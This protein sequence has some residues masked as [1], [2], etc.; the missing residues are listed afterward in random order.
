[1]NVLIVFAHPSKE[2]FTYQ[3]YKNLIEGLKDSGHNIELSDLYANDFKSDLTEEEYKREGFVNLSLPIPEDVYKEQEKL[4]KAECVIFIYPVWWSDC[5]AKLKGW[6]DRVYTVGYAYKNENNKAATRSMKT[7]KYGLVL[8]T[9]GH[10]NNYLDEIGISQS[11]RKIMID[12]RLGKRFEKKDMIIFGGT[13]EIENVKEK[14]LYKAYEIG[15]E[16]EHYFI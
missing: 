9:A 8:C 13:I 11:M 6:F 12:D 3:I 5:P 15:K 4:N 10:P 7:I 16:L 2:S 1:M 14:H